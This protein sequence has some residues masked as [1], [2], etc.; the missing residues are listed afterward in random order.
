MGKNDNT[1]KMANFNVT[2]KSNFWEKLST[3]IDIY[4]SKE[5]SLVTYMNIA[6][7]CQWVSDQAL[8]ASNLTLCGI[9]LFTSEIS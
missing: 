4:I 6:M 5:M 2:L 1:R 9:F 3:N 7:S 8:I